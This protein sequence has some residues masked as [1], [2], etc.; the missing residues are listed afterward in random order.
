MSDKIQF[1]LF[2]KLPPELQVMV[3]EFAASV[4]RVLQITSEKL[5]PTEWTRITANYNINSPHQ[6]PPILQAT[7]A[8]RQIALKLYTPA[9]SFNLGHPIYFN[10]ASD[11][12][13]IKSSLMAC[14][15]EDI[16]NE[17]KE[18]EYDVKKV[19]N[20]MVVRD[21]LSPIYTLRTVLRCS[22]G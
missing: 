5:H 14:H 4:P 9:F 8:S 16:K 18:V 17:T 10:F 1:T 21:W 15:D 7:S 19:Q 22:R 2:P 12:L 20:L 6:S 3:W 13:H 11:V